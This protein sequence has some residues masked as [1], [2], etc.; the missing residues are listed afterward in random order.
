MNDNA[1]AWVS[2]AFV[3]LT[4][5]KAAFGN[6]R[7]TLLQLERNIDLDCAGCVY[8]FIMRSSGEM[9]PKL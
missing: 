4:D 7:P 2:R 6:R 9:S 1:K 5:P 8:I 3:V